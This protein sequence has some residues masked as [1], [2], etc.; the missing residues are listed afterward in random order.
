MLTRAGFTLV[1]RSSLL[2][3]SRWLLQTAACL[4]H[5][6]LYAFLVTLNRIESW[7]VVPLA[8]TR[9]TRYY[10]RIFDSLSSGEAPVHL[11][12]TTRSRFIKFFLYETDV[13]TLLLLLYA[14]KRGFLQ[15]ALDWQNEEALS[16]TGRQV[17][18][19]IV[20]LYR[21]GAFIALPW[22]LAVRG[23]PVTM[24]VREEMYAEAGS[25]V[26]AAF[27]GSAC[28]I[29]WLRAND[30]MV[31]SRAH[32]TLMQGGVVMTAVEVDHMKGRDRLSV[33]FLGRA[34]SAPVGLCELAR[35]T[36]R[37]IVPAIVTRQ[38]GPSYTVRFGEP[39]R[40]GGS[41]DSARETLQSLYRTL[42]EWVLRYPDQ[43][44][45]WD[46]LAKLPPAGQ[47]SQLTV[48]N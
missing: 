5:R 37:T 35:T 36:G 6:L 38:D 45:G 22:L 32:D 9:I 46:S 12:A 30:P 26:T 43:W 16:G 29:T 2:I 8:T 15:H 48:E 13:D 1:G 31:L 44:L 10:H 17:D 24:I 25:R 14:K 3:R 39:L 28:K 34:V 21:I 40:V 23:I 7:L 18:G 19:A 20:C 47:P 41:D 27:L 4:P 33:E 42:E 11:D